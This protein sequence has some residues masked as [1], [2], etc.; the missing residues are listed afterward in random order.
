[1]IGMLDA[2]LLFGADRYWDAYENVHR[3]VMDVVI[4]HEV[5]EWYPLFD[6]NNR[7]LWDYMGHAWKI[8]YH[9]VRAAIQCE[10]RL[11]KL[12]DQFGE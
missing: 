4:N 8:N 2:C 7:R 5:G 12:L 3:F 9:T 11:A 10:Q 1:M 6:E